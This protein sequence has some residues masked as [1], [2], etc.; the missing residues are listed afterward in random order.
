VGSSLDA[1]GQKPALK[2]KLATLT[3]TPVEKIK[4]S[5]RSL[6]VSILLGPIEQ[7]QSASRRIQS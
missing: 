5:P 1:H 4:V 3:S 7:I 6:G 2:G